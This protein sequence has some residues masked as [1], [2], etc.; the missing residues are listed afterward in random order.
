M[1]RFETC[2][3]LTR[4][5]IRKDLLSGTTLV[6]DRYAHSGVAFTAAKKVTL[7]CYSQL[8]S[9]LCFLLSQ[10]DSLEWCKGPDRG[11]PSPDVVFYLRL[12]SE[13]ALKRAGYGEER[14]EKKS[15][16]EVSSRENA[17]KCA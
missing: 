17:L 15:F 11:L 2:I 1:Y 9:S 10:V 13:E 16:Q 8:L 4:S 12:S 3:L 14:Y 5:R 7:L 6:V